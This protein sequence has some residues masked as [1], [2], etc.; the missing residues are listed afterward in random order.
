MAARICVFTVSLARDEREA[1][2]IHA[3]L[4][5]LSRTG[6]PV[7]VADGGS[8]PEFIDAIGALPHVSIASPRQRGLV[9]QVQA[10]CAAARGVDA[11]FF[12]YLESDKAVF[13]ERHLADFLE[14]AMVDA[15]VGVALAARSDRSF[16]TFPRL[17]RL[18]ETRIN[19]MTG[20][21]VGCLGD[22]SYGPFLL[23]APLAR[24]VALAPASIGWGWRHFLFGAAHRLGYR[25]AH[26]IGDYECPRDQR[27]EDEHQRRHRERQLDQNVEGLTL[28]LTTPL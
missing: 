22:Y 9:A 25:L 1:R 26:V 2:L 10:A 28:S 14:R 15:D 3:T 23:N 18:N 16:A 7:I 8:P 17:Q 4:E 24:Y 12:L 27:H 21:T 19:E 11:R 5:H 20:T 6:L 13:A